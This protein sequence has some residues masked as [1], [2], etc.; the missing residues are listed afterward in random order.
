VQS[1]N[2]SEAERLTLS[3]A[4]R[5]MILPNG[6]AASFQVLVQ[7]RVFDGIAVGAGGG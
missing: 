1:E 2:I 7:E 5:E 3:T 6:M 4:V